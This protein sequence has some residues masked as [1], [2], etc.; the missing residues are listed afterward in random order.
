MVLDLSPIVNRQSRPMPAAD[1]SPMSFP[2]LLELYL[3][4]LESQEVAQGTIVVY[5]QR[6]GAFLKAIAATG[7]HLDQVTWADVRFFLAQL[8][9]NGC[10]A[11]T[12]DAYFRAMRAF[13]IKMIVEG[14]LPQPSPM[15]G[16]GCFL[17]KL[18]PF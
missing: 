1:L 12:I 17:L 2:R 6:D 18:A 5:R 3:S 13:F 11:S 14:I 8:K 10:V 7:L 9:L 4:I 16:R 15:R